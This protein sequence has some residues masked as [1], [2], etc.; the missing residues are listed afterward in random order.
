M[1]KT[2]HNGTNYKHVNSSVGT[3]QMIQQAR[4][5]YKIIETGIFFL[6]F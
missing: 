1:N 3:Q 2:K 6:I 5:D 4:Q